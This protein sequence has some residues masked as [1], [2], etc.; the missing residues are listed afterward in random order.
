MKLSEHF[1][2]DEFR[3][4]C[5]TCGEPIVDLELVENLERWRAI[6]NQDLAPGQEEHILLI[7]S[8]CRCAAW[9]GHEGGKPGSSHLYDPQAGKAGKAADCWSPTRSVGEIYTA[10]LQV[11]GFKGIGLAP[12]VATKDAPDGKGRPGYV[13]VDVRPTA[14]RAQWGYN[15]N[16]VVV[17]IA[18]VLPRVG[19][20][21]EPGMVV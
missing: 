1:G 7:T 17:A 3:C 9:N 16:G 6:L 8:G 10:A 20:G 12:P 5:G 14:T 19:I 15:D 13:H 21:P 11:E 4:H 18:D 2:V